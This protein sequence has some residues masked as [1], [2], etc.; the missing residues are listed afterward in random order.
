MAPED[1]TWVAVVASSTAVSIMTA[2]SGSISSA[3]GRSST[4]DMPGMRMSQSISE[5]FGP[6]FRAAIASSP[7]DAV[8]TS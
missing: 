1:N 2:I 5:N 8:V 4:P 3:L 7:L 6:A